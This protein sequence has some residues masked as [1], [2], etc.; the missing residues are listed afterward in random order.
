M[1]TA[2]DPSEVS[3]N[4]GPPPD[5]RNV[6]LTQLSR[7]ARG[8]NRAFSAADGAPDDGALA[9]LDPL[10]EADAELVE[11][12]CLRALPV[13]RRRTGFTAF[14]DGIQRSAVKLYHGPVP[15]IYA[16]VAAVVRGRARAAAG[17][18]VAGGPAN[19]AAAA[20]AV[21]EARAAGTRTLR[22]RR[23]LERE[24]LCFPF[25]LIDPALLAQAGFAAGALRDTS[26]PAGEALPLFPPLL[27]ALA[28]RE[29]NRLRE[30]VEN[31]L[32]ASW[33]ASAADGDR[34]LVDG[35]LT[36]SAELAADL[37]AVG[38]IKSHRTRFFDGDDARVLLGLRAGERTSIFRPGTR[39]FTPVYS[40]YLRLRQHGARGA[41]WGLVRIEAAADEGTLERADEISGWL[42]D[43]TAPVALPDPRWDRMLYPIRDCEEYLRSRAPNL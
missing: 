39:R 24:A 26:P 32:A 10:A 19:D 37:R 28:Q 20:A 21:D 30:E 18:G 1:G 13:A 17:N 9:S 25:R 2:P 12:P 43:E 27:Y 7:L 31:E 6:L 5:A 33:C 11:H 38:V 41:L 36:G 15:V 40:W 3:H 8:R 29:V 35:S 22:T 23:R 42:L 16:Y 14:L 34:L 4:L